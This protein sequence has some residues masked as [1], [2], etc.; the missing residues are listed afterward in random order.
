MDPLPDLFSKVPVD[1]I[2]T[3]SHP[4]IGI[5]E[6]LEA[7][8]SAD[9]YE[10]AITSVACYARIHGY[11]F[12]VI[13]DGE[14]REQCPQWDKFFRR[15][16]IVAHTIKDYDY[17]LFLDS[18]IGVVNPERRIEEFFDNDAQI[19][20]YDRFYNFEVMSGSYIVKNSDWSRDF[21]HGF[22]NYEY[23]LPNSIHGSDNGALHAY[24]AEIILPPTN[25]ELPTCFRVYNESKGFGDLF[26]FEACIRKVLGYGSSFGNIKIL[27]KAPIIQ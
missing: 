5:I 22:A 17:V 3:R 27:R 11:D 23:R 6:V 26:S 9:L 1:S 19:I 25:T 18:D 8:T 20:F 12:H 2:K 14:Y 21:L 10:T 16:C 4:R 7:R 15:H 13:N 24:L